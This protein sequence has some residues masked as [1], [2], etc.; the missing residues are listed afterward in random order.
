MILSKDLDE[1][2]AIDK[3]RKDAI[4]S[5]SYYT[6]FIKNK[7]VEWREQLKEII[8]EYKNEE[9]SDISKYLYESRYFMYYKDG[10]RDE[11]V[12][13]VWKRMQRTVQSSETYYTNDVEVL[14]D[15]EK[16]V[17]DMLKQKLFLTNSPF[18][19]NAGK[20]IEKKYFNKTVNKMTYDDYIYIRDNLK[21]KF[22]SAQCYVVNIEDS[23]DGIMKSMRDVQKI[24]ASGGGIGLNFSYLRPEYSKINEN[25]YSSGQLSFL[26][27]FN[28]LGNNILEGGIRRFAGMQIFG[29]QNLGK[30]EFWNDKLSFHPDIMEFIHIKEN[31][32]GESVLNNF[33]LSIGV[34][35]TKQLL[36]QIE[37]DELIPLEFEGKKFKDLIP[38]N[39]DSIYKSLPQEKK[40]YVD[41]KL[42]GEIS[43]KKLFDDMQKNAWKTGDPA[44]VFLDKQ[45]K[46]NPLRNYIPYVSTNPCG[47][48]VL[49]S[50]SKY[51][52][53]NPCNLQSID[54]SKFYFKNE[55]RYDLLEKTSEVVQHLLDLLNDL[56][57]FPLDEIKKG[58]LLFRDQG[59]GFMGLH[60][61]MILQKIPYNTVEGVSFGYKIMKTIETGSTYMSY[62]LGKNKYPYL[63]VDK[64]IDIP[65]QEIWNKEHE[66]YEKY[67]NNSY[68]EQVEQIYHNLKQ[69]F[70]QE[71]YNKYLRN[72]ARTSCA[73]TGCMLD[74]SSV[75]VNNKL[76]MSL[77]DIAK[78]HVGLDL[79]KYKSGKYVIIEDDNGD[80]H[81]YNKNSSIMVIRNNNKIKIKVEELK[82][83]D[84]I[85]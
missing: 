61:Q 2:K 18:I 33:N 27:S 80:I 70:Q 69:Y 34:N 37:D 29:Y 4:K 7:L 16:L 31:N 41:V 65:T 28:S 13:D 58:V 30:K 44:F 83:G 54:V 47:E 74:S 19:F 60:G 57:M 11:S 10:K 15:L 46:Y 17:Y 8:N 52:I 42:K 36:D 1:I 82:E 3:K 14:K 73:P 6:Q 50:S 78:N 32:D 71:G 81:Y 55:Y 22:S 75:T 21:T 79:D 67:N 56:M 38:Q 43:Q 40:D 77:K 26:K 63:A 9:L 48:K 49:L 53:I 5:K 24:S 12:E 66:E 51:N 62:L 68:Y 76:S 84:A 39:F 25:G 64:Q 35:N 72:Y 45:N 85:V 23:I 20:G 59:L